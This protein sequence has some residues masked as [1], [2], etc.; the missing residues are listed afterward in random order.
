MSNFT[1]PPLLPG[2]TAP[3]PTTAEE[4]LEEWQ[5]LEELGRRLDDPLWRPGPQLVLEDRRRDAERPR[6]PAVAL[7]IA[8][9][10]EA[11]TPPPAALPAPRRRRE[12]DYTDEVPRRRRAPRLGR[13]VATFFGHT[14]PALLRAAYRRALGIAHHTGAEVVADITDDTGRRLRSL[15]AVEG[16]LPGGADYG[17]V[18]APACVCLEL[19]LGELL[20]PINRVHAGQLAGALDRAGRSRQAELLRKWADGGLPMTMGLQ[21]TLLAALEKA[22]AHLQQLVVVF[23][24]GIGRQYLELVRSGRLAGL[25]ERVRT[26]Y[27]NPACHGS[28]TFDRAEYT[29]LARLLLTRDRFRAWYRRGPVELDA[30]LLDLHLVKW[31]ERRA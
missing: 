13:S 29:A 1:D 27:R 18:I 5:G 11:A 17:V 8:D 20:R 23:G 22:D 30:G 28:R 31:R 7:D 10:E 24:L 25:L 9:E 12:D 4:I 6:D 21:V 3:G 16:A 19:V 2:G 14:L 15:M 26:D